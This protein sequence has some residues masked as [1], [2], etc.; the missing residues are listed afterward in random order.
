MTTTRWG[1][2]VTQTTVGPPRAVVLSKIEERLN[3][4]RDECI[5]FGTL[6][7]KVKYRNGVPLEEVI[8][9]LEDSC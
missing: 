4:V 6:T 2:G 9:V 3:K 7:I 1:T 5:R 8:F